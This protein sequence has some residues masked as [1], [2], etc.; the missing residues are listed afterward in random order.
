MPTQNPVTPSASAT[1]SPEA[2]ESAVG[3]PALCGLPAEASIPPGAN[4][5][6][7]EDAARGHLGS[8]SWSAGAEGVD[9]TA[10]M[11][12]VMPEVSEQV[13]AESGEEL[14]IRVPAGCPITEWS[15]RAY[16]PSE[17]SRPGREL[18]AELKLAGV[19]YLI[20]S[21]PSTQVGIEAFLRFGG[22][23]SATY[24]WILEVRS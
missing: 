10:P 14:E 2:S 13:S 16:D 18:T 8:Y 5:S 15:V 22:R 20:F 21:A 3:E 7:A 23:G 19:E 24:Y 12:L 1:S 9:V 6:S 4:L 17:P 11:S